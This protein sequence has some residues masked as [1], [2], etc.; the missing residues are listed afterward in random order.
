MRLFLA[1]LD[2]FFLL[3]F[4]CFAAFPTLGDSAC[5]PGILVWIRKVWASRPDAAQGGLA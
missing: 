2:D 3:G 5:P 4:E 1:Q